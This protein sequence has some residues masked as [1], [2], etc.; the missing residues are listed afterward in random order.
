MAK[1]WVQCTTLAGSRIHL[2][3]AAAISLTEIAK[4]VPQT[5]KGTRIGFAG[6]KDS[7]VDVRE[8][9][10]A[11]LHQLEASFDRKP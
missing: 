4:P 9:A 2:Q 5:E 10:A 6:S 7:Y 8:E 1:G 3:V 11:I